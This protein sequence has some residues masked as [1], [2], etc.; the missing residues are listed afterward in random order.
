MTTI[1]LIACAGSKL[2]GPAPAEKLYTSQLFR[3]TRAF[4]RSKCDCWFILS[5]EHGLLRPNEIVAPYDR[6]LNRMPKAR[7]EAWAAR[8]F[9]QLHPLLHPGDAIIMLAGDRYRSFL[10]PVLQREGHS[11]QVPLA[12]MRIGEQ[13]QW[14]KQHTL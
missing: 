11:V 1:G 14:L 13:L 6:T 7:R 10:M 5:A 3:K 4:V 12:G 8:V 2:C 9:A